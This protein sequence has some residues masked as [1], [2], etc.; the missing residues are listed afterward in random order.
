MNQVACGTFPSGEMRSVMVWALEGEMTMGASA[1][2]L[3][4]VEGAGVEDA[5]VVEAPQLQL[6]PQLI[7]IQ[8]LFFTHSPMLA[9]KGQLSACLSV[10]QPANPFHKSFTTTT[11]RAHWQFWQACT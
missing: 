3:A 6:G 5:V 2:G 7:F 1:A 10:P 4:A 8:S 9:Q 11:N